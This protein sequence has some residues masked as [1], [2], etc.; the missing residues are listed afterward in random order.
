MANMKYMVLCAMLVSIGVGVVF[1]VCGGEEFCV[2]L[3]HK[4]ERLIIY[5]AEA[6]Q[7]MIPGMGSTVLRAIVQDTA[8]P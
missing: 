7:A 1:D 6:H 8:P 3:R 4:D 5:L 2:K